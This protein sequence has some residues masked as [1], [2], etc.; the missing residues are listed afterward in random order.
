VLKSLVDAGRVGSRDHIVG[1][2]TSYDLEVL[3]PESQQNLL[4]NSPDPLSD[5]P[6]PLFSVFSP[7]V[8][9]LGPEV[10]H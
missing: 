2:A 4:K 10:D 7:D 1:I 9:R 6:S 3:W 8:D 5:S